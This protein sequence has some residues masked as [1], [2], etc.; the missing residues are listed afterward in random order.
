MKI[1]SLFQKK[2]NEKTE[3]NSVYTCSF[4]GSD[5]GLLQ[6]EIEYICRKLII[7]YN[8]T[9]FIMTEYGMFAFD[10]VQ[11]IKKEFPFIRLVRALG[12]YKP[13]SKE[14]MKLRYPDYDDFGATAYVREHSDYF[15][16]EHSSFLVTNL[17]FKDYDALQVFEFMEKNG[18]VILTLLN[19]NWD[20]L[21]NKVH[22]KVLSYT[23]YDY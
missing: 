16:K 22:K 11:S 6:K 10:V 19:T 20:F 12:Y 18:T 4:Y 8:V 23:K 2:K 15:F 3:S 14:K 5:N 1:L 7:E 13:E 9:H 17:F 21:A